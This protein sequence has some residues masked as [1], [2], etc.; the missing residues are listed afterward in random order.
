MFASRCCRF[1]SYL[2]FSQLM[3]PLVTGRQSVGAGL[4][5][6]LCHCC[7]AVREHTACD[8]H[9]LNWDAV[10]QIIPSLFLAQ[11]P[12]PGSATPSLAGPAA[13][14]LGCSVSMRKNI[15]HEGVPAGRLGWKYSKEHQCH[16]RTWGISCFSSKKKCS[17]LQE[18]AAPSPLAPL[19][20]LLLGVSL[21]FSPH[22]VIPSSSSHRSVKWLWWMEGGGTLL[23]NLSS[24]LWPVQKCITSESLNLPLEFAGYF[25][26]EKEI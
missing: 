18:G 12:G 14:A 26:L 13:R 22:S 3:P 25:L 4:C 15:S 20:L 23:G 16:C 19:P 7:G 6:C 9:R 5:W 17:A 10:I 24:Y 21:Q 1:S 8:Q 11:L 2:C